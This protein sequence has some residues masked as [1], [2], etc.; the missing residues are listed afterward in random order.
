MGLLPGAEKPLE[1][2]IVRR[3]NPLHIYGQILNICH[4]FVSYSI[5]IISYQRNTH[6]N[7]C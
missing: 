5:W 7:L 3:F 6:H 2:C 1:F 4:W